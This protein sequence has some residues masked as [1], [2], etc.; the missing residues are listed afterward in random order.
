MKNFNK[1]LLAFILLFLL[2][3]AASGN[4][5]WRTLKTERFTVFYSRG[6]EADAWQVLQTLEYYRPQ[7]EE[8]C[9]NEAFHFPVVI[10]DVG[11][12]T[13]GFSN[14]Q[15]N[16]IHLFTYPPSGLSD[17]PVENWWG[18]VG[19]H[20]YTH[21]LSLSK[22]RGFAAKTRW[23]FGNLLLPNIFTPGWIIEGIT[24]YSESQL[25]PLQGRLNDGL[26]NA[27]MGARLADER[28]PSI[29]DATY[30]PLEFQMSGIYTYGGEFF[31]YLAQTYGEEKFAQFFAANGAYPMPLIPAI[32]IDWSAKKIFGKNFQ[33]LWKEWENYERENHPGFKMDG[34]P[35]THNGWTSGYPVIAGN[36]LYYQKVYP[37]KTSAFNSF[38]FAEIVERDL[39][40]GRERVMVS[41]PEGFSVP[42][43]K[44]R[45]GKLYYAANLT[46]T[47]FA[48]SSMQ[49]FGL[50]SA[51]HQVNPATRRDKTLLKEGLRAFEI[52]DDGRIIYSKDRKNA[53]GSEL[54]TYEP[55][56]HS[57][58]LLFQSEY[59]IDEIVWRQNRIVVTARRD[60]ENDSIYLLDLENQEFSPIIDT[61]YLEAGILLQGESL[62]FTANYNRIYAIYSYDFATGKVYQETK[63]GFASHPAFNEEENQ[64]YYTGLSSYGFDIYHKSREIEEFTLP[65]TP[66]PVPPIF[67]LNETEVTPGNYWDNLKTL[68]PQVW[69]PVYTFDDFHKEIGIFL[70][71]M[72][73]IEDFQYT[74]LLIY[75]FNKE[76]AFT[77]SSVLMNYFNPVQAIIT[78]DS[79]SEKDVDGSLTQV[80][81]GY[82]IPAGAWVYTL[83]STFTYEDDSQEPVTAPYISG[84]FQYPKTKGSIRFTT[85]F[86]IVN[87]DIT[88]SGFYTDLSVQQY[89]PNSEL[90]LKISTIDDPDNPDHVFPTIRGYDTE[91]PAKQGQ[92]VSLDYSR[93]LW[94]IRK[95]FWNPNLYFEDLIGTIF[96]DQA[97]SGSG[98]HQ[99]S[100]GLEFHLE[101]NTMYMLP[102]DW[103][104]RL[105]R[106]IEGNN[107]IELFLKTVF[108]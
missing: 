27:Y 3:T 52:M 19:V 69:E 13:N 25:D 23:L 40:N 63:N 41:K 78:F 65:D 90:D 87:N 57:K 35:V 70:A 8:L 60:W 10:D 20:E 95:G 79:Y 44:I 33:K 43:M 81:L 104:T 37:K 92:V 56:T 2:P 74:V 38:Y 58:K 97:F 47:G 21:Q 50:Q 53:F 76:K 29:L 11:T 28:W 96:S 73:A 4:S 45:N 91:L 5:K 98:D 62:F 85:P 59:L 34:E 55:G 105:V 72:D 48:N 68:T 22:T 36:K 6:H 99:L 106:N 75:D 12:F 101:T 7:V 9:G 107:R 15:F 31:N 108:Y 103:G 54:Y 93:P 88:R 61:P 83:G 1:L 66:Q 80:D 51:I 16:Q 14:P 86:I 89:L 49:G 24:V 18:L 100:W 82:P 42:A 39:T 17:L 32:G 67:T 84:S 94:E 46:E 64:L 102:I 77:T 71:G 26:F 30:S